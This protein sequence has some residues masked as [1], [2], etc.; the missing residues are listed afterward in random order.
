MTM[1]VASHLHVVTDGDD[2]F[3]AAFM[4][5]NEALGYV[6]MMFEPDN[7]EDAMRHIDTC[8]AT[9]EKRSDYPRA[10]NRR[11]E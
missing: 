6:F 7:I 11:A 2:A 5:Y 4:D 8:Y 10:K 3:Q 1:L 9:F